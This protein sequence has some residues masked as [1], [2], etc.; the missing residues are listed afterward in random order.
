MNDLFLQLLVGI[1]T[2]TVG[3]AIAGLM[4]LAAIRVEVRWHRRDLDDH[5]RR[6]SKLED[7][8]HGTHKTQQK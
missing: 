3:G 8:F 2:G 7:W 1:M 5:H 4:A 6:I